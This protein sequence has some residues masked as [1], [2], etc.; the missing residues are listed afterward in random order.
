MACSLESR[1]PFL[2]HPFVEFAMRV[3]GHLKIHGR[4]QK[5][6][7]KKAVEDLLPPEIVYRKKM[8]FPTPLRQWLLDARAE[9]LFS[10]LRDRDGFLAPYL[11]LDA[12]DAL[13]EG[14]RSGRHDATD[15]I[16]RL[17]NLQIWGDL[18]LTGKRGRWWPGILAPE[19]VSSGV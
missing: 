16:W 9:T 11:N 14:Q 1:V 3:P 6:L 4:T 2:D 17:L 7:L 8:G 5:Y 19:P 13:I 15:R 18:F 10:A 12:V